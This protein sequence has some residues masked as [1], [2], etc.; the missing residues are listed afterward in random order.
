MAHLP[1][2]NSIFS[3]FPKGRQRRS[4]DIS[5]DICSLYC[6]DPSG[7]I[8]QCVCWETLALMNKK[9]RQLLIELLVLYDKYGET[10]FRGLALALRRGELVGEITELLDAVPRLSESRRE[11]SKRPRRNVRERA[12]DKQN[13][14]GRLESLRR[15]ASEKERLIGDFGLALAQAKVLKDTRSFATSLG[16]L[17]WTSKGRLQ[18]GGGSSAR[19]W[20]AYYRRISST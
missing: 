7:S 20:I 15:G 12:G 18:R 5:N 10:S 17:G 8:L 14:L 19:L 9:Q 4:S 11:S 6:I 13:V 1:E 2:R 16:S 3:I